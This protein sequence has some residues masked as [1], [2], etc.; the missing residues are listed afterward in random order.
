MA[1]RQQTHIPPDGHFRN[2][3]K[4]RGLFE[5]KISGSLELFKQFFMSGVHTHNKALKKQNARGKC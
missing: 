5:R 2:A 3:S 4:M 1:F